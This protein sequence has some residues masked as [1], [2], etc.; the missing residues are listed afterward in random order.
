M[1]PTTASIATPAT[2]LKT[3]RMLELEGL[4]EEL[5]VERARLGDLVDQYD[6]YRIS[7]RNKCIAI[8]KRTELQVGHALTLS[9]TKTKM[10]MEIPLYLLAAAAAF[11]HI[12][13]PCCA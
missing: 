9:D 7:K 3:P 8:A 4:F 5:Q 1:L 6:Q 10:G 12:R 11:L 2:S 13:S